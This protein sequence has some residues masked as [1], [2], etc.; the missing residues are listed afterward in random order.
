MQS[1]LLRRAIGLLR[2]ALDAGAHNIFPRRWTAAVARDHVI[3]IQVPAIKDLA[4]I[5]AGIVV[6]LE[7][8]VTGKFHFLLRHA[9]EKTEQNH[10][11]HANA[12]RNRVNAFRM[13]LL[14]GKIVPLREIVG[15]KRSIGIIKHDLGVAFKKQG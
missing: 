7:N 3:Q 12:E 6:A 13:R 5:L 14:I 2:I 1:S 11:R 15:L 4:A 8:V 10:P 9:I